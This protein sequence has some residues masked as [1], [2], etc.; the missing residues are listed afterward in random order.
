MSMKANPLA[1]CRECHKAFDIEVERYRQGR[2]TCRECHCQKTREYRVANRG[3]LKKR[4]KGYR[5][6]PVDRLQVRAC[7]MYFRRFR[8]N[9]RMSCEEAFVRALIATDDRH[10][11]MGLAD[12]RAEFALWKA[13]AYEKAPAYNPVD[14]YEPR[15]VTA[16][17]KHALLTR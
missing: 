3:K 5:P 17:L 16:H 11:A 1:T 7:R 2:N 13:E 15:E 4:T 9:L 12:H 8:L 14:L 6:G 10:A